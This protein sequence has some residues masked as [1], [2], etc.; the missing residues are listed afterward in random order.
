MGIG[1]DLQGFVELYSRHHV[2]QGD[3]GNEREGRVG[4]GRSPRRGRR[5]GA[6]KERTVKS[7]RPR[8]AEAQAQGSKASLHK[9]DVRRDEEGRCQASFEG[10]QGLPSENLEG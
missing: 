1:G 10:G 7:A 6:E 9:D 4:C 3:E 8:Q 2:A 5:R